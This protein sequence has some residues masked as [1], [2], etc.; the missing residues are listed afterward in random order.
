MTDIQG[1]RY[2]N[3]QMTFWCFLNAI[4]QYLSINA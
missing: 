1:T 4:A 3:G 2:A